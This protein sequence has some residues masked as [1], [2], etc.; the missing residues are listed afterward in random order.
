MAGPFV[1]A[2]GFAEAETSEGFGGIGEILRGWMSGV[3]FVA[4]KVEG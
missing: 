4:V 3:G 2:E 1:D